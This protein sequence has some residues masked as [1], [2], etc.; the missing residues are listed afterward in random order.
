MAVTE[1]STRAKEIADK[2]KP[3]KASKK[4]PS[5]KPSKKK[6]D[7]SK[8]KSNYFARS[9]RELKKVTWPTRKESWRLTI[10]VILFAGALTGIAVMVDYIFRNIIERYVI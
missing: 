6:D 1:T 9:Y 4:K 5:K 7:S 10:A 3:N 2:A 8:K